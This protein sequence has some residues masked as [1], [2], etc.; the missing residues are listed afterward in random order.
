MSFN[1]DCKKWFLDK[2][3]KITFHKQKQRYYAKIK[4][5][6]STREY[7]LEKC[8]NDIYKYMSFNITKWYPNCTLTNFSKES[9]TFFLYYFE[10]I[11]RDNVKQINQYEVDN[12][13]IA[14]N[15][16][17]FNLLDQ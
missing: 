13:I 3:L 16:R 5:C 2:G 6:A 4:V 11:I 12:A 10:D 7:I 15:T 1:D 17:I 8:N 14:V 9:G